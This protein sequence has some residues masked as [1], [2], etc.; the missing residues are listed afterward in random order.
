MTSA[1]QDEHLSQ[2]N[3]FKET[4]RDLEADEDPARFK[5]RPGKLV[6]RRRGDNTK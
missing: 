5:D 3:K 2:L 4:A 1:P 6:R